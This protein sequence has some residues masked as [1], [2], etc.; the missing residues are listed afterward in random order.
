MLGSKT[1]NPPGNNSS[2]VSFMH[3]KLRGNIRKTGES[4]LGIGL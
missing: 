3:L 1:A 4:K 2:A